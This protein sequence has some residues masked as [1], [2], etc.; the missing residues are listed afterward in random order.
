MELNILHDAC[1]GWVY[2]SRSTN[3]VF[4]QLIQKLFQLFTLFQLQLAF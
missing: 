3:G 4:L 2:N 1:G